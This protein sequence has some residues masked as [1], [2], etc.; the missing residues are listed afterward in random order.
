MRD[1]NDFMLMALKLAEK[2][3]G[4]T[5]PNPMV[6]A[7]IV[8]N[9]RIFGKG[10]HR[11]AGC[12]HAEIAAIKTAGLN[13]KGATLYVNLEPCNHFGRT[14][15]CTEAIIKSGIKK[16]VSA[17][18]D[19][20]PLNN[21]NGFKRLK[22]AG[23]KIINGILEKDAKK[24]NEAFIKYITK[25]TP[26]VTVKIAESLDGKIATK[27]RDSKWIS[28]EKSRQYVHK[29]RSRVDAIMVG[30]RTVIKDNPLLTSR[31]SNKD[32][33]QK[34]EDQ[35]PIKIIVDSMLKIPSNAKIFSRKS[36]AKVIIAT[37][38]K[39]PKDRINKFEKIGAEIIVLKDVAGKADLAQLMK[40]L[41]KREITSVLVEG[42]GELIGSLVDA[43]LVDKF[44]FFVTPK[45]IGG[46]D[47]ITSVEGEGAEKVK[48]GL[49]LRDIKYKRFDTDLLVEGYV[50]CLQA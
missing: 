21:G 28:N 29:L 42:G 11:K 12:D 13:A 34:T 8:K 36:P 6:G 45:I 14:P 43:K 33:R 46:R 18:K 16:V 2:G 25:K 10:Y 47:A 50:K 4:K 44:L 22:I 41:G 5:S 40:E 32:R 37:T 17:M 39:A 48:Q 24:L 3:L 49:I 26:F 19:P 20:N 30:A 15:P 7:V 1:D 9:G 38:K 31:I 35:R 23:I 27:T